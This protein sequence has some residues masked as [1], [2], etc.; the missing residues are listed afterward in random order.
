[1]L[2]ETND[3]LILR[4]GTY[5]LELSK[6]DGTVSA[7][8]QRGQVRRPPLVVGQSGGPW[9]MRLRSGETVTPAG[10]RPTWQWQ[11]DARTLELTY[12]LPTAEVALAWQGARDS[13]TLR[14][15]V[16]HAEGTILGVDLPVGLLFDAQRVNLFTFPHDLG[17]GLRREWFLPQEGQNARSW[18]TARLGPEH[19]RRLTGV[20]CEMREDLD[21]ATTLRV[22]DEGRAWLGEE[23]SGLLEDRR[24]VVNRPPQ[25]GRADVVLVDSQNGPFLAGYELGGKGWFLR[26]CAQNTEDS[27]HIPTAAAATEHIWAN[28]ADAPAE[29]AVIALPGASRG[30]WTGTTVKEWISGLKRSAPVRRHRWRVVSLESPR[31]VMNALSADPPAHLAIINPYGEH[32]PCGSVE[33]AAPM[34][35]AIRAYVQR[36]GVWW[37]CGGYPFYYAL[38]P[39][40]L[41]SIEGKY[42]SLFCDLVHLDS[43]DGMLSVYGVQSQ[44]EIFVPATLRTE[45]LRMEGRS[46]GSYTHRF[47]IWAEPGQEFALPE[48]RFLVGE[49]VRDA[50]LRYGADNG[51]G[52]ALED[53]MPPEL[54]DKF[55]NS[56]LV[57]VNGPTFADET[58]A[59]D[60]LPSP[61]IVHLASYM[62]GGFDKQYPDFLPPNPAKGT[63]DDLRALY[64]RAH[65]LGMLVMPYL[66]PTWWCDDPPS[67]SLEKHGDVALARGLDGEIPIER[68]VSNWGYS[69]T[70]SHPIA[71]QIDARNMRLFTQDL[72]SDLIFQDQIGARSWIWD[73]NPHALAPYGYTQA[74]IDIAKTDCQIAP[75]STECGFDRII[76]YEAQFCGLTWSLVPTPGGPPW[77]TFYHERYPPGTWQVSPLALYLAHDKVAFTHHDLGQRIA[78]K[79]DLSL[80][81]LLGYQM[82]DSVGTGVCRPG[83]QR[84]EWLAWL[85]AVQKQVCSR[86]MGERLTSFEEVEP[87]VI[88]ARCGSGMEWSA[89]SDT[90]VAYN[91]RQDPF[92]SDQRV[93]IAPQGFACSV[94]GSIFAGIVRLFNT[95]E[96]DEDLYIIEA[97]REDGLEYWVYTDKPVE[98]RVLTRRGSR[99]PGRVTALRGGRGEL[100]QRRRGTFLRVEP[101]GDEGGPA[102][103]PW[104]AGMAPR[105][106]AD[107]PDDI[108][109]IALEPDPGVI[110]FSDQ[111]AGEWVAVLQDAVPGLPVVR[112]NSPE[113]VLEACAAGPRQH[114][115]ILNP[116][117]EF[118]PAPS[119]DRVTEMVD[120]IADY[121]A[122]GGV[123]WET[124]GY[125]LYYG[126]VPER[127]QAGAVTG[128]R[129]QPFGA[130]Q[131]AVL[132]LHC[133]MLPLDELPSALTVTP[134]GRAVLGE[135]AAGQLAGAVAVV[136]RPTP[137]TPS[138]VALVS[139]EAGG[140]IVGHQP[141]GWG[142][143]FRVGGPGQKAVTVPVVRAVA[144][145]TYT[146]PPVTLSGAAVPRLCHYRLTAQ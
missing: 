72:P 30:G 4:G 69:L 110:G 127:D 62:L 36:G 87:G 131:E 1:M 67:P 57:K 101:R 82:I 27:V 13:L 123:W 115:M 56:V 16:R 117:G 43:E 46:L 21:P 104:A 113:A 10:V 51:Y 5:E 55:R 86:Y 61:C 39:R 124:A 138:S 91:G 7:L 19:L 9:V 73:L 35:E 29:V 135:E 37:E 14:A 142:W 50:A 134:S 58:A 89:A 98:V 133:E 47:N 74:I 52:R 146:H 28:A 8:R 23:A 103:P 108:A 15:R 33:A 93:T 6:A 136:N 130:G 41:L 20:D 65:E 120:A 78:G 125:S 88:F 53:K 22:T 106:W 119:G 49:Q 102:I 122:N 71:K 94:G 77:R 34:I 60:A 45:A 24:E 63:M 144:Q 99:T 48:L 25:G 111:S 12:D 17:L 137:P 132:G 68:Y 121:V 141:K 59:L 18:T 96:Y 44:D 42:P 129:R 31:A 145:Y 75:L 107:P 26:F 32:F 11:R 70:A 83:T 79:Q 143:L 76:D 81:L 118:F 109:V 40:E 85:D 112:L 95:Q 38:V 2:R 84:M 90:L 105:E 66:N 114:L 100:V 80:S 116:Y 64:D 140:Y 126:L 97:Q 128:W 139:A 92:E 3:A 54:L